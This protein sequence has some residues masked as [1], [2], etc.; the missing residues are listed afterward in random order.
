MLDMYKTAPKEQRD[1][2]ELMAAEKRLKTELA[3]VK[4]QQQQDKQRQRRGSNSSGGGGGGGSG[5]A[6]DDQPPQPPPVNKK[7]K[8]LEEDISHLEKCLAAKEQEETMLLNEMEVKCLCAGLSNMSETD[9]ADVDVLQ[10]V[11]SI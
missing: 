5:A 3:K 8:K 6:D 4:E 2:V 9:A 10:S 11:S 7:L 1:K